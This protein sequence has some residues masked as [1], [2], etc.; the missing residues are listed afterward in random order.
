M[1]SV[2]M[3]QIFSEAQPY[4]R[5][6]RGKT[7]VIKYG[8]NAMI[9][10]ELKRAVMSDLNMLVLMGIRVVLVHGGGPEI[11]RMLDKIGKESVFI[12]GLRYTDGETIEVVQSV[13]AGKVNKDLVALINTMGGKAIGMCGMD[14]KLLTCKK[15]E[16]EKDL[17]FVGDVIN[18]N[19]TIINMAL[20]AGY[21]P[22]I[23]TVGVD[24][25]GTAY[26]I[27]ADTAAAEIAVALGAAKIVSMTDVVGILR[28][29]NDES[30]LI[31]EIEIGEVDALIEDGIIAGGMIPKIEG[32]VYGIKKGMSEAVIIDG[33]VPHSILLE[34]FSDRGSGTLFYKK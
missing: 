13:L 14:G 28:D 30:T 18:V 22:V 12:D 9:N 29:K 25:E 21:I 27:N 26:N 33:R 20:D 24:A 19:P 23:A 17:G 6:Y 4:V 5:K 3:A 32:C 2:M 31:E 10:E 1:K 11:N 16:A 34:I 8:G 7:V 15:H